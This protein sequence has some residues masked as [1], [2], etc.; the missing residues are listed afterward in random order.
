MVTIRKSIS[1]IFGWSTKR[2]IVV[3]ESDDWGSIRTRSKKDYEKMIKEGLEVDKSNFTANDCLESNY[4]LEN[5]FSLLTKHKDSTSR[6]P[7][8]TPMAI[9]ANPDFEKI[10][11]SNFKEYHFENFTKTYQKYPSHDKVVSL[12][13]E[14]IENRLFVP[15]LHGREHL[16][17]KKWLNLLKIGNE[18]ILKSFYSESIGVSSF[19]GQKIPDYLAAFDPELEKDIILFDQI[20]ED[21]AQ[22][23]EINFGYRPEHFIAS[24]S[25]EPKSM[26]K[27]L[28][29][30]GI[31]Y[32]TRYKI[33]NYPLGNGKF[34][35]EF[36]WLGKQN[37]LK[38][39]YLTRNCGFEPSDNSKTDWVNS[40]LMEIENAFFWHKPAIISSHRVNYISFINPANGQHGLKQLDSL[41]TAII[42][43]WPEVEF[44]TSMELGSLI[45]EDK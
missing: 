36:N 41:L 32:L 26:E 9:M 30:V 17:A 27:I 39:I 34:H 19:K 20:I 1:N 43:K 14:G 40:C 25:S 31:K 29:K 24:N 13:K 22:L 21:A 12:W 7:V 37:N 28:K 2:K 6:P 5:L 3:I 4:D 10:L 44:M 35:K 8:I 38:Q 15:A 42:K 11:N 33:Q 16:N 45:N 18:G 23:F